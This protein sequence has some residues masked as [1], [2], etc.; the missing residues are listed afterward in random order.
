MNYLSK[1][2]EQLSRKCRKLRISGSPVSCLTFTFSH[3]CIEGWVEYSNN[4][5]LETKCLSCKH[6]WE[7]D[8]QIW[9][10]AERGSVVNQRPTFLV[11]DFLGV[12]R[13]SN[14][15]TH[16]TVRLALYMAPVRPNLL[17]QVKCMANYQ[18]DMTLA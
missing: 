14:S 10:W 13:S 2:A 3:N 16:P 11:T 1:A 17:F 4:N 5:L 7:R 18:S 8:C 12:E 15:T 6:C 9:H